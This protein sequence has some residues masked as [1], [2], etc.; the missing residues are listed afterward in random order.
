MV[1][2]EEGEQSKPLE[3]SGRM[4]CKSCHSEKQREFSGE[5]AI[6]CLGL[7]GLDQ[8][9]V[10]VFPRLVVCL[11][12]GFTEFVVPETELRRLG[13]GKAAGA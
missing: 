12:C 13:E 8:P 9:I 2:R 4:S 6:H 1:K 5:V 11:N 7:K 10:W 3:V